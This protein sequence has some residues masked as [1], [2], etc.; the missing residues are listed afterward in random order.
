MRN[1]FRIRDF[2]NKVMWDERERPENY[3]I[4][5]VSRG[6]PN[7]LERITC[8]RITKIYSRGFEYVSAEGKVRYIPFHRIVLIENRKNS[9]RIFQSPRHGGRVGP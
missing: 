4:V 9:K 8:E 1:K 5:Y 2:L 7:G 3:E 6:A